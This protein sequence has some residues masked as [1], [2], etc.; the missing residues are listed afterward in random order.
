VQKKGPQNNLICIRQPDILV[1]VDAQINDS[2]A[3]LITNKA[4]A[5][6]FNFSFSLAEVQN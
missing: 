5:G 6:Q 3:V 1:S 2:F 4:K